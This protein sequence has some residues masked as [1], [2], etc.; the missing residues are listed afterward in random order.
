LPTC[1]DGSTFTRTWEAMDCNN[2]LVTH[3]QTITVEDLEAPMLSE[4]PADTTVTCL[5]DIPTAPTVTATDNC[6]TDI[7]VDFSETT[8]PTCADGSSFTRTWEAMDCNNNLVTHTQSIT[9]EDLEAP[10]LFEMPADTT[11]TCLTDVPT[12]PM[13][14]ATDNCEMDITVD[15]T[16]TA[17]PTCADG[18]SFTRTWEAMDC[19]NNLV[20]HT[21]TITVEDLEAP[22]LSEMPADTTVTCLTDIPTAPTVTATDNCETGITVDFTETALPTCADGSTFTRT[23]EA[24]SCNGMVIS[25]SQTITIMDTVRPLF[26]T[27]PADTTVACQNAIPVPEDIIATD[28]C[29]GNLIV[30]IGTSSNIDSTEIT[31]TYSAID[32]AG[33][34]AIHRQTINVLDT[35]PPVIECMDAVNTFTTVFEVLEV[36]PDLFLISANDECAVDTIILD[37]PFSQITCDSVM[38]NNATLDYTLTITDRNGNVSECEVELFVECNT[39]DVDLITFRGSIEEEANKLEWEVSSEIFFSHYELERSI[40]GIDFEPIASLEQSI[41]NQYPKLYEFYD[42]AFS[43]QSYYRLKMIDL[44]HSFEY[45]NIILLSREDDISLNVYPNPAQDLIY[46]DGISKTTLNSISIYAV[47]G[48]LYFRKLNSEIEIA[49]FQAL[50][51]ETS[52]YPEGIYNIV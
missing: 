6:E 4:M 39:V 47:N 20:T 34:L 18:S 15:F 2:N 40:N 11:V 33:N 12:A 43:N 27:L 7:T 21:Q 51:I 14:T 49:D 36:T 37:G 52:H 19:N 9:V 5:T 17:I 44:D 31:Y 26:Q 42:E 50:Q 8:I 35:T 30:N 16:E 45:S 46:I 41:N 10:M 32:C 22:M 38:R 23:W 29:E 3:T 13:V 24:M 48:Q 1:A 25:H 28:A